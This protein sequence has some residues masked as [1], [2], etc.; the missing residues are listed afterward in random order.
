MTLLRKCQL[1]LQKPEPWNNAMEI[2]PMRKA[3]VQ[4]SRDTKLSDQERFDLLSA[5]EACKM[6]V[7]YRPVMARDIKPRLYGHESLTAKCRKVV[8]KLAERFEFKATPLALGVKHYF[9]IK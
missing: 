5:A 1:L 9:A 3:L 6:A 4:A 2:I 8:V 7:N